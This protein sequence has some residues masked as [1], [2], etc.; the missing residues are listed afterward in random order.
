MYSAEQPRFS[1]GEIS[2][3]NWPTWASYYGANLDELHMP[4]NFAL[5]HAN[6][7]PSVV[8]EVIDAIHASIPSEGWPNYVLGNHDEPRIASRV[9]AA[10]ARVAMM[11]LLTLRGT[12]TMYYGDEIGMHDVKIPMERKQDPWGKNLADVGRDPERTPMQWDNRP[13]AGFAPAG[14]DPW[15]PLAEDYPQ[16]NVAAQLDDS[17]SMLNLTRRLLTLRKEMTALNVGE[18]TPVDGLPDECLA[19]LRQDDAKRLA[20]TLNFC[21]TELVL[22]LTHLANANNGGKAHV[23]LSTY[24]DR[25]EV[26]DLT[27]FRLRPNEGCILALDE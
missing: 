22:S 8:R 25:N 19:Y 26:A 3:R 24:L 15:L 7:K 21:D 16:I 4:F 20:I 14:I 18:Y 2:L 10:Q 13:N 23:L 1:V 27:Q 6:W 9:G 5:I 11:L 12:P 17:Y